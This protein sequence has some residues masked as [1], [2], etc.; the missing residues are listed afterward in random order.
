[1][2]VAA[3]SAFIL[4]VHWWIDFAWVLLCSI[5]MIELFL[6]LPMSAYLSRLLYAVAHVLK[7]IASQK[8]SDEEKGQLVPRAA[9]GML[10]YSS[11]LFIVVIFIFSTFLVLSYWGEQR[12]LIM[13]WSLERPMIS[14]LSTQGLILSIISM[15]LYIFLRMRWTA[16]HSISSTQASSSLKDL[17]LQ[18]YDLI[19]QGVHA[20]AL[21]NTIIPKV[22]QQIDLKMTVRLRAKITNE[23]QIFWVSGLARA[24][25]SIL[26][27]ILYETNQFRSLTYRDMPFPL[28]PNLWK[29]LQFFGEKKSIA[30]ERAHGDGLQVSVDSPEALEEVFWRI[31]DE[32]HYLLDTSIHTHLVTPQLA[33]QFNTYIDSVLCKDKGR[34]HK[35]LSKNNNH[36]IRVP[37]LLKQFPQAKMIIP[38]RD[39]IQ[40]AESLRRQHVKWCERHQQDSFSLSY[41]SWLAHHEFGLDHR[42]FKFEHNYLE[43]LHAEGLSIRLDQS[44]VAN[45]NHLVYWLI[46]WIEVYHMVLSHYNQQ[47]IL[48]CYE[49]LTQDADLVLRQL[50]QTINIE[51]S[52]QQQRALAQRIQA[53]PHR[54]N[55]WTIDHH[56]S[57]EVTDLQMIHDYAYTIYQRLINLNKID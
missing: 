47:I 25:T 45:Q 16:T 26:T 52:S 42:P 38:F 29:K 15:F 11:L 20:I 51:V 30:K 33:S 23:K 24:G 10:K 35:Y 3:E 56:S 9:L 17:S 40:H 8:L 36:M 19:A 53:A 34:I 41:M 6:R 43:I 22:L 27:D 4:N 7:T 13:S 1:M 2:S 28:S 57:Q 37:T 48:V 12:L 39:P 55:L 31:W 14:L 49:Q 18:D 32:D 50:Y 54:Q 5:L 44:I 46:R 21:D